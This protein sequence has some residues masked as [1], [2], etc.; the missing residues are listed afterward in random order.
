MLV[1]WGFF[2]TLIFLFAGHALCDYSW[3]NDFIAIHKSHK[4]LASPFPWWQILF[5][6]SIIHAGMVLFI[7]GST[8]CAVLELLIHFVTD[9]SKCDGRISFSADQS[10][11]YLCKLAWAIVMTL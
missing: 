1:H 11:H 2:A 10:I 6:H 4:A 7:T 3:Q 5:A 9:W 8:T